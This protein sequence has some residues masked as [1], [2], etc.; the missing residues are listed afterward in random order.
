MEKGQEKRSI[1]GLIIV[2]SEKGSGKEH[3]LKKK[4]IIF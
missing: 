2:V 3:S 1:Q 4:K